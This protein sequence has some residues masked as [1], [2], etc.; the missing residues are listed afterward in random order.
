MA[1]VGGPRD[2]RT[3]AVAAARVDGA[4]GRHVGVEQAELLALVQERRAAHREQQHGRGPGA[5]LG[6]GGVG[7]LVR[8]TAVARAVPGHV[9]VGQHPGGPAAAGRQRLLGAGQ[10]VAPDARVPRGVHRQEVEREV[11]LV[12]VAVVRGHAIDVEQVHLADHHALAGVAVEQ[13]ADAAQQVVGE[14]LVVQ[15]RVGEPGHLGRVVGEGRVLADA[16]HHVGPEAVDAPVEPEPQHVVHGGLDL[17][18]PPVEVGLLGQEEVEV[19]LVGGGI[20]G[21]GGLRRERGDPVVRGLSAGELVAPDVPV[22]LRCVA[23]GAGVEEP[24][25]LVGRVVGD[26]V[27]DQLDAEGMGIGQEVVE[28]VERPEEGIDGTEVADVVAEVGHRRPVDRGEPQGVDAE[29]RQVVEPVADALEVAHAVAVGVGEAPRVDLV[30][31]SGLPPGLG[32]GGTPYGRR[33]CRRRIPGGFGACRRLCSEAQVTDLADYGNAG[34]QGSRRYT[35]QPDLR[36]L[37]AGPVKRV[38]T[39]ASKKHAH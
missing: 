1:L 4:V 25:V 8:P 36:R 19:G 13:G 20:V 29:P 2:G 15:D 32:H 26:P 39:A 28:V 23:G 37:G 18:V 33:R 12:A 31:D 35:L 30:H 7:G 21:P 6:A 34:V 17:R 11:Q 22:P 14:R 9:V 24:G 10:V 38:V 3:T 16:V 27:E 5:R